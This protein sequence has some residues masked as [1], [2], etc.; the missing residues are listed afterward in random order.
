M[1][2]L[3]GDRAR[4]R[5]QKPNANIKVILSVG[6]L[7]YICWFWFSIRKLESLKHN[8]SYSSSTFKLRIDKDKSST[9]IDTRENETPTVAI[10]GAGPRLKLHNFHFDRQNA[11]D[12]AAAS[13]TRYKIMT[14]YI[15]KTVS[16]EIAG[17]RFRGTDQKTDDSV[18]PKY[19]EPLP[20]R[21]TTP[22]DLVQF[23]YPN[24]NS[25]HQLTTK[26]P[27]D[28]GLQLNPDGS[29]VFP[30]VNSKRYDFDVMEEAKFCPVDADPFL[31]WIHDVFP[32]RDGTKILFIAQNKRRC[33]TGSRFHKILERLE[34]QV[35][36]MQPVGLKRIGGDREAQTIA[37]SL[38]I[39]NQIDNSFVNGMD[40]YRLA[41]Y[42]DSD[43]DSKFTRYICRFHT[44]EYEAITKSVYDVIIG[45][46]F[47]E[48]A[49]NYE[50]VSLRKRKPSMLSIQGK[51]NGM[52][53]LSR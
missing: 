45:E 23:E 8:N 53:W 14:A 18:P 31:P 37:P 2:N 17:T 6:G 48:F 49:F 34:P 32:N 26:L 46:T 9:A 43:E 36:L 24:V 3:N 52:F 38:W 47:S 40:R 33:N 16:H 51:D 10:I 41:S 13:T 29:R 4:R 50:F 20:L 25:C 27:V 11:E 35:T 1:R 15:E 42:E 7:L 44:R 30:N 19:F 21:L 28:A 39:P 12:A 5:S 22:N